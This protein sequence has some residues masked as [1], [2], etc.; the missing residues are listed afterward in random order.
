MF[1]ILCISGSR[2]S[3]TNSRELYILMLLK[4]LGYFFFKFEIKV[5]KDL[6]VDN[7]LFG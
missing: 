1:N 4:T 7:S 2:V 3:D 5:I 6:L